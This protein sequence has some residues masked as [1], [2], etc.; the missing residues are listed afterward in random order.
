MLQRHVN[1]ILANLKIASVV[2]VKPVTNA[3][4]AC[5]AIRNESLDARID[6]FIGEPVYCELLHQKLHKDGCARGYQG[7]LG[8][9][10]I[11]F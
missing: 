1:S 11:F 7:M 5:V 6:Y 2:S 9:S 8:V 4:D 10:Q 3:H